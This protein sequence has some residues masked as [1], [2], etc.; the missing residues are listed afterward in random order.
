MAGY[1][2]DWAASRQEPRGK[3]SDIPL[4]Q[5]DIKYNTYFDKFLSIGQSAITEVSQDFEANNFLI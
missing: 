1:S 5:N 3:S 4:I 2:G